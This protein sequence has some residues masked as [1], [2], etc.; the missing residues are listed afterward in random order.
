METKQPIVTFIIPFYNL[1]LKLLKECLDSILILSLRRNEREIIVVDDGSD[2]SPINELQEYADDII[3]I[4][5]KNGGLS[6]ARNMGLHIATGKFVQLVDA[7]DCLIPSTYEQCLDVVRF[8]QPDMVMFD[9]TLNPDEEQDIIPP[10]APVSGTEYMLKNNIKGSACGCIFRKAV[11]MNL[12]FTTGILHEDEEFMPQLIIRCEKVYKMQ[13]KAY[14]YR[15]REG[16]IVHKKDERWKHRRVNDLHTVILRLS[17]IADTLPTA[18]RQAMQRRVAQLTMDYIYNTIVLLRNRSELDKR[19]E[20]LRKEGLF[21]LPDKKYTRKYQWFRK[22]TNSKMG[23]GILSY[24]L[25]LL[26][27]EG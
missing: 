20:Q 11:L 27:K 19:L 22:L 1:P 9:L 18:D 4:R 17:A 12:R 14:F 2:Y 21:P 7:D 5:K 16:S 23:L 8:K 6:D 15:E 3:Y 10:E 13:C 25:P 26:K 24:T